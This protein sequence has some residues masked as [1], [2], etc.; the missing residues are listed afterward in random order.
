M[1]NKRAHDNYVQ[2]LKGIK[3]RVRSAQYE[4]LRAVNK[5]LIK[6]YCDIGKMIVE[7]QKGNTWGKAVVERLSK[8]LQVEFPKISGFSGRNLWKMRD[9]YLNYNKK[10]KLPQL[11]AEIGWGHNIVIMEK[12]KNDLEQHETQKEDRVYQR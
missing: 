1:G 3:E 2:L 5:E 12:C 8:D 6:L 9:F 10:A 4:A 11:V 7:Q